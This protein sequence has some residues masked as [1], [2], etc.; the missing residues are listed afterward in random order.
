MQFVNRDPCCIDQPNCS[1]VRNLN[2]PKVE[3]F[4]GQHRVPS[5]THSL[6]DGTEVVND[7]CKY[8]LRWLFPLIGGTAI[9]R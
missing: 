4:R 2:T 5:T 3:R 7:R 9:Q 1:A 6:V 8:Q